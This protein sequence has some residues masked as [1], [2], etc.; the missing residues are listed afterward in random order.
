MD[1]FR[2]TWK[3]TGLTYAGRSRVK[4]IDDL[5]IEPLTF[6]RLQSV[7]SKWTFKYRILVEKIIKLCI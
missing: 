6:E 1:W 4:K 2:E 5:I 3:F 7:N